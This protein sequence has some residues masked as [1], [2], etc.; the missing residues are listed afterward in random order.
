MRTPIKQRRLEITVGQIGL[1]SYHPRTLIREVVIFSTG[2]CP[3]PA[4]SG[5]VGDDPE[6]AA[7]FIIGLNIGFISAFKAFCRA[8]RTAAAM[9]SAIVAPV[10]YLSRTVLP[11]SVKIRGSS[12][13]VEISSGV[14]FISV[15]IPPSGNLHRDII[16]RPAGPCG[17]VSLAVLSTTSF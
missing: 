13:M 17:V 9:P 16:K 4:G 14:D 6:S 15:M 8:S 7:V 2:T 1:L 12:E 5:V 10:S 11:R 3:A